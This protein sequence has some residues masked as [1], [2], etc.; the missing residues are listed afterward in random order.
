M[1]RFVIVFL[2]SIICFAI[3]AQVPNFAGTAGKDNI[4]GYFSFKARPGINN[5][6]TYS[7]IQYGATNWIALGA[8]YYTGINQRYL[9]LT[10]RL[11][12]LYFGKCLNGGAQF[13]ASFDLEDRF[14]WSYLTSALY[15]NGDIT[16]DGKLFY[17]ADTWYTINKGHTENSIEQWLYLAYNFQFKNGHGI[18]PMIGTIYSWKFNRDADLALG[19]YYSIGKC[20]LYLWGNDFFKE[21]PRVV[22]GIEFK[23]GVES[24]KKKNE[25][26]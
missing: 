8:D 5:Q 26:K 15:L 12:K 24:K 20:N 17:V 16:S 6:E 11:V 19:A 22:L 10:A 4:Y 14:K 13:T 1:K 2:T 23:F 18:T 7:T 21:R 9:G 3:R 25:E